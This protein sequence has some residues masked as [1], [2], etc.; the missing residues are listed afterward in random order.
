MILNSLQQKKDCVDAIQGNHIKNTKKWKS[1]TIGE[2]YHNFDKSNPVE[3]KFAWKV[4]RDIEHDLCL[5]QRDLNNQLKEA[6]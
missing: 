6:N 5:G 2:Q 4:P 3:Y 1:V